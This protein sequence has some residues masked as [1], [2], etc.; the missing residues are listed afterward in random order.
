MGDEM[1][2]RPIKSSRSLPMREGWA[3]SSLR[4]YDDKGT[5][6]PSY[7]KAVSSK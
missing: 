2:S 3:D 5:K 6:V 4:C 7:S 1:H